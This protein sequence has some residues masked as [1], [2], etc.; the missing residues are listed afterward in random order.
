MLRSCPVVRSMVGSAAASMHSFVLIRVAPAQIQLN[1]LK[2]GILQGQRASRMAAAAG[3]GSGCGGSAVVQDARSGAVGAGAAGTG[4]GSPSIPGAGPAA[5]VSCGGE[6]PNDRARH[7]HP[8][9]QAQVDTASAGVQT[10]TAA[11]RSQGTSEHGGEDAAATATWSESDAQSDSEPESDSVSEPE[12]EPVSEPDPEWEPEGS[13]AEPSGAAGSLLSISLG[14]A[15]DHS[16]GGTSGL[17]PA[18]AVAH[19]GAWVG[20]L[21]AQQKVTLATTLRVTALPP[22]LPPQHGQHEGWRLETVLAEADKVAAA[23]GQAETAALPTPQASVM[24]PGA[25]GPVD[26]GGDVADGAPIE[27]PALG[28]SD[29]TQAPGQPHDAP[30]S[31]GLAQAA[32]VAAQ[33]RRRNPASIASGSGLYQR[34]KTEDPGSTCN[35]PWKRVRAG[36]SQV[37]AGIKQQDYNGGGEGP[38]VVEAMRQGL[39]ERRE[40]GA[41]VPSQVEVIDLTEADTHIDLTNMDA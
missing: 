20:Q 31:R 4:S 21:L 35:P 36:S 28:A 19:G 7:Q 1:T 26:G 15:P 23:Q 38:S 5:L 33:K 10:A 25:V 40:R 18:A 8:A 9:S 27:A 13:L 39:S 24:I 2:R 3:G 14:D 11:G 12:S 30:P 16:L 32:P 22:G 41:A 17:Q 29:A 37:R 6:M 34:D